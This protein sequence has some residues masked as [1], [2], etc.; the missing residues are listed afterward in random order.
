MTSE[1]AAAIRTIPLP[2]TMAGL[3]IDKRG[4]PAPWFVEWIDGE[5]DFRVIARGKIGKAVR[6]SRCWVCGHKLGRLKVS[7]IGPMCAVNRVSS[8]PPSHP[9]CARYATMACPF[10]SQPRMRRNA[11]GL[12]E[13]RIHPAGIHIDRNPGVMVLWSSLH[14]SKPFDAMIGNAGVLFQLGAPH[15]VEWW[16]QRRRARR[17][18]CLEALQSGLPSLVKVAEAEGNG[19][20]EAL[21]AAMASAL[22]LLPEAA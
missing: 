22:R 4:F 16:T 13:E 15:A 7:V 11:R 17:S 8:E 1:L 19:A 21:D 5:P 14:A 6:E 18:E 12:P 2:E 9:Q 3:A 20:V 10:L